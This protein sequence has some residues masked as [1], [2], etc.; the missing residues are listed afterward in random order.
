METRPSHPDVGLP[1]MIA[2]SIS[3]MSLFAVEFPIMEIKG[4][5]FIIKCAY[6]Q[7]KHRK[8]KKTK[9]T[10]KQK[11]ITVQN[12]LEAFLSR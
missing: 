3:K 11:K 12:L 8:D 10:N 2:I 6:T 5:C 9:K 1:L 7:S 4:P